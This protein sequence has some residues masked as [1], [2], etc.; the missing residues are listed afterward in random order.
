MFTWRGVRSKEFFSSTI[1]GFS[2]AA[3]HMGFLVAFYLIANHF[4]A[5]SPQEVK[6]DDTL[7][8][9][10][11]WIG[12]LAIGL[13]A[14][15]SEEFLFRLFAIPYLMNLTKSQ[16]VAVILPAFAWGF[17]HTAY[18]NEPPYI[19]GLEVGLIGVVAGI[20]ML[21][22]ELWRRWCGTTR[23]TRIVGLY[24]IRSSSSYLQ[25]FGV[26]IGLAVLI[27]FGVC[28]Y[29]RIMARKF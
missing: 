28:V 11:P 7:N 10:I 12:G 27:P 17:L 21:R 16:I 25:I 29:W 23:W 22:W 3:A 26:V 13:L 24:L 1:V 2:L 14:A 4:G 19:R 9:S 6:Y 15:T 18:P 8:T 20:V 5:W